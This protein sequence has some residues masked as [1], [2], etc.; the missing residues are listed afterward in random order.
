MATIS[1]EKLKLWFFRDISSE[2]RLKLFGLMGMPID[3]IGDTHGHQQVAFRHIVQS[4]RSQAGVGEAVGYVRPDTLQKLRDGDAG[5]IAGVPAFDTTIP[6]FVRHAPI[7]IT[8]ENVR[9]ELEKMHAAGCMT[10]YEM[11]DDR[12]LTVDEYVDL[13]M[14][15]YATLSKAKSQQEGE[16]E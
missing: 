13:F 9:T 15:I 12:G 3:E 1:D 6:L 16:T 7:E 8:E 2:Q 11:A 14:C 5:P 10:T 4:L